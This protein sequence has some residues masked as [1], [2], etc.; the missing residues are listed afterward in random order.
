MKGESSATYI[1]GKLL[2][3][4]L[5]K[6]EICRQLKFG[7]GDKKRSPVENKLHKLKNVQKKTKENKEEKH[8][9]NKEK[10][11]SCG[12]RKIKRND[13]DEDKKETER[14]PVETG[15]VS[16]GSFG[17]KDRKTILRNLT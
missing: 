17:G 6:E 3:Y 15:V 8:R 12:Q 13:K 7:E 9:K 5:K 10:R 11:P 16:S 2:I 14:K 1:I 4:R